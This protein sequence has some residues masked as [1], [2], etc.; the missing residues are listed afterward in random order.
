MWYVSTCAVAME[1]FH[2]FLPTPKLQYLSCSNSRSV[3]WGPF[4]TKCS[5]LWSHINYP[6]WVRRRKGGND[7]GRE[8]EGEREAGREGKEGGRKKGGF[9]MKERKEGYQK[10]RWSRATWG[11]PSWKWMLSVLAW[12]QLVYTNKWKLRTEDKQC[13]NF[14][15][16]SIW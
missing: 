14:R 9:Q 12:L 4:I 8:S 2:Y 10:Y 11:L 16:L 7:G 13:S 3:Y 15:I 5:P 6:M 1:T